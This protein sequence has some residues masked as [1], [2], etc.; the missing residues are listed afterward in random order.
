MIT[1]VGERD[2]CP[3][4]VWGQSK[5]EHYPHSVCQTEQDFIAV[6]SHWYE[7]DACPH[8]VWGHREKNVPTV[9]EERR[10]TA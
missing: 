9:Y 1:A 3:H 10:E 6:K 4:T 7:K 2:A 8:T 5:R